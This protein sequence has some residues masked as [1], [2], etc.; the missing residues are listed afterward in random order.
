MTVHRA[1]ATVLLLALA[2]CAPRYHIVRGGVAA[3]PAGALVV[4]PDAAWNRAPRS[5]DDLP[6]T[7]VW[8]RNGEALDRIVLIGGLRDGQAMVRQRSRASGRVPVFRADMAPQDIVAMIESQYRITAAASGFRT[9]GLFPDEFA[10]YLGFT[11]DYDFVLADAVPRKGRATG[12]VIGDRLYL[13]LFDAV[14]AH[15]FDAGLPSVERI[16]AS[17]AVLE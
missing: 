8:T 16:A 12:A 3:T 14:A 4:L 11:V 17:A 5:R 9:H 13:L 15:Y 1:L 10:G 7:Q 2:A 6:V